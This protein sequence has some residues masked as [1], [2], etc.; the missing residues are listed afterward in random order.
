MNRID[1][2]YFIL[3]NEKECTDKTEEGHYIVSAPISP[4]Q[5]A[6]FA[7]ER[8]NYNIIIIEAINGFCL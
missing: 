5:S 4:A 3:N 8:T 1:I 7:A 2:L 6:T